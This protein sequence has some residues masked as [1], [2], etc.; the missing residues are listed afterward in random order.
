MT[1]QAFRDAYTRDAGNMDFGE[2]VT[3]GLSAGTNTP[4]FNCVP[5]K[6]TRVL[7]VFAKWVYVLTA[8]GA[9]TPVAGSD[10]LDPILNG[11]TLDVSGGTGTA[12]R[13]QLQTR[14]FAEFVYAATTNVAFT[15][16]ALPTFAS[17][18]AATVTVT[19]FIP[20]GMD[21]GKFRIKLPGAITTSSYTTNVTISYTSITT[22]VV[23]TTFTGSVAFR[24]ELS[25]SLGTGLQSVMG[26]IPL[27][28][29]PNAAFMDAETSTTIT[30]VLATDIGHGIALDSA[31]TDALQIG[32]A[33]FAPIASATYTTTAG[34]VMTLNQ[35]TFASFR[36]NFTVATTHYMG[37][38]ECTGGDTALSN[39]SSSPTQATP[40]IQNQGSVTASGQVAA[41]GKGRGAGGIGKTSGGRRYSYGSR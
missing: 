10:A 9:K 20:L 3:T 2:Q 40:A 34:F 33:A 6:G 21:A 14:P 32:A 1:I 7:G 15:I 11:G 38:L 25:P 18:S 16:A 26:W 36:I 39:T 30:Q 17:A 12:N 4:W 19:F 5:H 24:Q 27:D 28:I 31:D 13:S 22:Q 23:S 8:S 37:F 41:A 29:A 35:K